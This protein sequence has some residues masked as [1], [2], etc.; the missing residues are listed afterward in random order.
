MNTERFFSGRKAKKRRNFSMRF[1]FLVTV[2][3]AMVSVTIFVGGLSVYEVDKYIQQQ[4]KDFVN[5]T[6][7]NEGS[8]IND[9]L[10]NMEKSVKIMESYLIDFFKSEADVLDRDLQD[11]VIQNADKMFID[12]IQH[13]HTSGAI[14]Y[15]FRFNP[16]IA[17]STSGLFYSKLAGRD[18]FLSLTPTDIAIYDRDDTEHVGWFW[19]PYDA[20]EPIWMQPYYNQNNGILMI[21]YV[22]P[23]YFEDTFI[24][25]VGMDFDYM[26]LAERVHGITVYENGFAHL[27][28]DGVIVC[29][30]DHSHDPITEENSKKY[31][32]VSTELVN[33]ME[34]IL[35]ASYS[36]IRQIRDEITYKII[37][38]VLVLSALFTVVAIFIVKKVVDPLKKLTDASKKLSNGDYDVEIIESDTHEIKL[39]SAAFENMARR[40]REREALLRSSANH[41]SLTGLRNTT[42]YTS[43]VA[44]YN[45]AIANQEVDFGVVMLDLNDLKKTNDKYG[46]GVGDELIVA[47]A[48]VISDIFK[49][50]PI[51]RIGGDEFLVVLQNEDLMNCE[52]L[53]VD[54][55]ANC[56]STFVDEKTEIPVRIA[57]GFARYDA[58]CDTCFKDVFKRADDAMYENK[59]RAKTEE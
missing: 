13:T 37:G 6:C 8:K 23:M 50:S 18:E 7:S 56:A 20:G 45:R 17:D 5:I 48:N 2:I 24:G 28:R 42:S 15:Y 27:G 31:M 32:S 51:F 54:L 46:H 39:L 35:S 11:M 43:W 33:G 44:K 40:L 53:F 10:G 49:S 1:R 57:Y 21:S 29:G 4:A 38:T 25:V 47:A 58:S 12:V 55:E 41:D 16:E 36:D 52:K 59:R 30:G 22:I 14:A 19:Q 9:S 3:V 34:L 26:V